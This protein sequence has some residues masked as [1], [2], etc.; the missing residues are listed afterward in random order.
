MNSQFFGACRTPS[1]KIP[2]DRTHA[3]HRE[4]HRDEVDGIT[5]EWEAKG[6]GQLNAPSPQGC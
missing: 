2:I 6:S 5:K 4:A 1:G 3:T